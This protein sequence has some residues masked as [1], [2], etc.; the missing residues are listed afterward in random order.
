MACMNK[1]LEKRRDAKNFE[2][3]T[4]LA[5]N[6]G[7]ASEMASI[8]TKFSCSKEELVVKA[9]E[10]MTKFKLSQDTCLGEEGN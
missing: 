2:S 8:W 1:K 10:Y 7:L 6:R 3:K 4:L 5:L 9:E